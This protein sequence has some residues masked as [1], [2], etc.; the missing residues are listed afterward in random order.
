VRR[1]SKGTRVKPG[2]SVGSVVGL[3]GIVV[4]FGSIQLAKNQEDAFSFVFTLGLIMAGAGFVGHFVSLKNRAARGGRI[5][6]PSPPVNVAKWLSF[7]EGMGFC[8]TEGKRPFISGTLDGRP[9]RIDTPRRRRT[10]ARL[11][12]ARRAGGKLRVRSRAGRGIST[13]ERRIGDEEFEREFQILCFDP[14]LAERAL[15]DAA[16]AWLLALG[17]ADVEVRGKMVTVVVGGVEEDLDRLRA[18]VEA[19]R[20]IARGTAG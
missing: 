7:A 14:G 12:L 17:K 13:F 19:A 16:R 18:L 3:I 11:Q 2:A 20:E 4:I 6:R 8:L 9:L 10:R 15:T 5:D 1:G